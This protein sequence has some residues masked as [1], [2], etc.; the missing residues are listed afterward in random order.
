[1]AYRLHQSLVPKPIDI[2]DFA[3]IWGGSSSSQEEH[4]V[5]I[6]QELFDQIKKA[7]DL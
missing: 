3:P 6:T 5:V 4:E 7:H 1:M 2:E